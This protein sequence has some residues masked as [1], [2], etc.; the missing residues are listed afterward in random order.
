MPSSI[1][2]LG[3]IG[4]LR[5]ETITGVDGFGAGSPRHLDQPVHAQVTLRG[6][7]TADMHRLIGIAHM[8]R[9]AIHIGIDGYRRDA[10]VARGADDAHGDFTA[11]GNQNLVEWSRLQTR[12]LPFVALPALMPKVV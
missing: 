5:Q 12:R 10:E 11:I 1:T 9:R 3:E 8:Q 6:T 2:L 4:V 7:R